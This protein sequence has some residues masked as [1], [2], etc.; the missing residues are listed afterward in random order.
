MLKT[1]FTIRNVS[2]EVSIV[3]KGWAWNSSFADRGFA[4]VVIQVSVDDDTPVVSNLAASITRP[5]LIPDAG[6]P[7]A[8]H[9]FKYTLVG[10]AAE[11]LLSPGRH[12]LNVQA[13]SHP[14]SE[15]RQVRTD[16]HESPVAFKDGSPIAELLV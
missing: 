15:L 12:H 1:N 14:A 4:P 10:V 16:V 8:E 13:G 5:F 3:I 7:N 2:G 6:A 11:L 9:G